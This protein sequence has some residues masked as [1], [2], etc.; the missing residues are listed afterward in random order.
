M[1][2]IGNADEQS[3]EKGAIV[4]V[5]RVNFKDREFIT[6]KKEVVERLVE[7]GL[8]PRLLEVPKDAIA[9]AL[10]EVKQ[11]DSEK[12]RLEILLRLE[13]TLANQNMPE[14]PENY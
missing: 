10:D 2:L 6:L 4:S 1:K 7:W 3:I 5:I 9:C 11:F 14:V 8:D 12:S 13:D